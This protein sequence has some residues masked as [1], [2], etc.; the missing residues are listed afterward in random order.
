MGILGIIIIKSINEKEK[1]RQKAESANQAKSE[2][3]A[4]MSHEIRTPI[5]AIKGLVHLVLDTDLSIQ[6]KDYLEKIKSSTESLSQLINDILDFS[7]IEAGELTLEEK[8]F[9]L[10]EVLDNLTNQA[11][12]KASDKGL[13]FFY[14]TD[15]VP[16]KLIGDPLRLGQILLN[17]VNNAIKFTETG[18]V[19]L[20]VRI[21]EKTEKNIKLKF[22]VKD[23]GIGMNEQVQEQLF[24]KFTQADSSTTRKY[25]GTGLG[26]SI[27]QK[28]VEKMAGE[29]MVDSKEGVGSTFY[30][31]AKFGLGEQPQLIEKL[32]KYKLADKKILIVDDNSINRKV[33]AESIAMF[34]LD[35]TTAASAEEAFEEVKNNQDY[36]LIFMDWK[37]PEL[38]GIKAAQII[39]EEFDLEAIPKIMLITAFGEELKKIEQKNIDKVLFKP[40]TQSTLFNAIISSLSENNLNSNHQVVQESHI[41]DLGKVKILIVEDNEINQQIVLELLN[42][43]NAQV[44][45][46]GNGKEAVSLV[47]EQKFDLVLMDVQ[48]PEM[49]GYQATKKIRQDLNLPDLPIIAMTAN[50]TKGDKEQALAVGMDDYISKPLDLDQFFAKIKKWLPVKIN[51]R[52]ETSSSLNDKL[53]QQFD[54][55]NALNLNSALDKVYN[56]YQL[57]QQLL[58]DFYNDYH[59]FDQLIANLVEN[60]KFEQLAEELHSLKGVAGNIGAA[61]LYQITQE[62]NSAIKNGRNFDDLLNKFYQKLA[63]LIKQISSSNL[64]A[65]QIESDESQSSELSIKKLEEY[66]LKLKSALQNYE[67]VRAKKITNKITNYNW[68]QEQ[69]K[70]VDK[71]L[72]A[73][74]TYHFDRAVE[75]L[76]KLK[77][78]LKGADSV[79]GK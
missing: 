59:K 10:D 71:L 41:N 57:Y 14:D 33:L 38:D 20:I 44:R 18:E 40:V 34:D 6:Q 26:L 39:K 3:L 69:D 65:Q 32:K 48:M 74:N 79:N 61:D 67:A 19:R 55:L 9:L 62:L 73:V 53:R 47:K 60:D 25:G 76:Q 28:L 7:K 78:S 66:I 75:L 24:E 8:D 37:M 64:M 58:I 46:A 42:K 72:E 2:F 35:V 21:I 23:T 27:S 22:I 12:I 70:L 31:S 16:Q 77:D 49:D 29:I 45:L 30:F 54:G 52:N 36:D 17:L 63:V 13:E 50:A 51:L 5:N 1:A 4:N 43:V 56:N 11:A 68:N 15:H